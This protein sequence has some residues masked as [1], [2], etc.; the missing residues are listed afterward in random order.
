[1]GEDVAG[2]TLGIRY[3]AFALTNT[4]PLCNWCIWFNFRAHIFWSSAER[5]RE[6]RYPWSLTMQNFAQFLVFDRWVTFCHGIFTLHYLVYLCREGLDAFVCRTETLG[7]K[8][9]FTSIRNLTELTPKS[10]ITCRCYCSLIRITTGLFT[11]LELDDMF[12][13]SR[14]RFTSL[15]KIWKSVVWH[16]SLRAQAYQ[17]VVNFPENSR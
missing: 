15:L 7:F 12:R 2:D 11:T 4:I 6:G 16:R 14:W 5:E 8:L 9:F 10:L 1:M 13:D 3:I 17:A